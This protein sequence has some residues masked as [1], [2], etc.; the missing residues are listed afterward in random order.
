MKNYKYN[1][2]YKYIVSLKDKDNIPELIIE[3]TFSKN[4]TIKKKNNVKIIEIE[5]RNKI[6]KN[7]KL[8]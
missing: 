4:I 1:N 6:Y 7:N 5:K 8:F 2:K 3:D